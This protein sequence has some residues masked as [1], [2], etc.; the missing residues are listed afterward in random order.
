M[1]CWVCGCVSACV[2]VCAQG[3]GNKGWLQHGFLQNS[4]R[5]PEMSS[6]SLLPLRRLNCLSVWLESVGIASLRHTLFSLFVDTHTHSCCLRAKHCTSYQCPLHIVYKKQNLA[7]ISHPVDSSHTT[8]H[9][10]HYIQYTVDNLF[11][12]P[13]L[14]AAVEMKCRT[15]QW[16]TRRED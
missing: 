15:R 6:V 2:C 1:I 9:T 16:R 7:Y 5:C 10:V 4:C 8:A 12:E 11:L 3:Q 14:M 13:L